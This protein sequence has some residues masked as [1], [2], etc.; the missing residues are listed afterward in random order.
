[1]KANRLGG[2]KVRG[3][4]GACR[5]GFAKGGLAEGAYQAGQAEGLL[6]AGAKELAAGGPATVE[7]LEG[8]PADGTIPNGQDAVLADVAPDEFTSHI[9]AAHDGP[10][11]KED[12]H[13]DQGVVAAAAEEAD[14]PAV[15]AA[16]GQ[17]PADAPAAADGGEA[18]K[19][20][21]ERLPEGP[22]LVSFADR[23]AVIDAADAN[24]GRVVAAEQVA[25]VGERW[26]EVQAGNAIVHL[27]GDAVDADVNSA[28]EGG[29]Q[30]LIDPRRGH[31]GGVGIEVHS[32]V[33]VAGVADALAEIVSQERLPHV[34]EGEDGL[35]AA[36]AADEGHFVEDL[37]VA[38]AVHVAL[39]LARG[40]AGV[41]T[42]GAAG[43]TEGMEVHAELA[44]VGSGSLEERVEHGR[45]YRQ[46]RLP[47][48]RE[49]EV[50]RTRRAIWDRWGMVVILAIRA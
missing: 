19:L 32:Q 37:A 38:V 23:P 12:D 41:G 35:E 21:A 43:V 46:R 27:W 26:V 2:W 4:L 42:H 14:G 9:L 48:R 5:E 39:G 16:G 40:V 25:D 24:T 28:V 33:A 8:L 13:F 18:L 36:G 29:G 49:G 34:T 22:P 44:G 15:A 6:T 3:R 30:Q 1:M 50:A 31:Q 10:A 11:V 17:E 45:Q 20:D 47:H 7:L